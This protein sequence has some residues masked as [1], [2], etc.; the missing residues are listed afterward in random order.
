M[1][2]RMLIEYGRNAEAMDEVQGVTTR[3][4]NA[5]ETTG[6]GPFQIHPVHIASLW[7]SLGEFFLELL[8]VLFC[9]NFE[10]R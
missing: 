7:R 10:N 3:L 2:R 4:L 9:I 5:G 8:K 1:C 6:K